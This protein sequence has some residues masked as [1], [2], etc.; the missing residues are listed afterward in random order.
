MVVTRSRA[1]ADAT[2]SHGGAADAPPPVPPPPPLD[3]ACLEGV[4]AVASIGVSMLHAYMSWQY[5]LD[6][7][8]KF[9]LTQRSWLI[10]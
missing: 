6:Y 3:T 8:T 4:R 2:R 1:A 10:K 5:W 9:Q 7:D